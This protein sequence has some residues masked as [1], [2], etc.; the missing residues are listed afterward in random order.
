LSAQY[1]EY[2]LFLQ[3]AL[4]WL[5]TALFGQIDFRMLSAVGDGFAILLALLRPILCPVAVCAGL[6]LLEA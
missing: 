4:A 1:L 6:Y 3:H 2:K 5:Q